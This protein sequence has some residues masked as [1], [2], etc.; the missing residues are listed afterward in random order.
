M[1]RLVTVGANKV[2]FWCC[3]VFVWSA[4]IF[5]F[6]GFTEIL[7]GE[8]RTCSGNVPTHRKHES[9]NTDLIIVISLFRE[10]ITML[11]IRLINQEN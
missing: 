10:K 11:F 6:R 5:L 3:G 4:A 1:T 7:H 9:G 8:T 2:V